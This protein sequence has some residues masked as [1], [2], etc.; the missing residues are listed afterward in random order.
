[1]TMVRPLPQYG[2]IDQIR[3]DADLKY[4]ALYI[5]A[6][7][8]YSHRNQFLV[9]YTYTDSDDNNPMG[10]YL[11]NFDLDLDYGPS[12]GERQHAIVASGS[13]L[14]PW[15][16]TLGALYTYRSELPWSATAGRDLNGDTFNTDLVPGTTRNAGARNLNLAAVNSY[17]QAN[18]L[19]PIAAADIDS[20]RISIMDMRVSKALRFGERK[21][22]LLAQAFNVLNTKNLQ[23]QFGGG[24]VG[25]ALS[26]TFGR[27]T[28]ARASR[29]I[30]LAVRL[31]W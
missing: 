1:V 31:M 28:S 7:K 6:E 23:A 18:G 24:R 22:D 14:L 29:Q 19:G 26:N 9:S 20:S 12:G 21:I 27:I 5:K 15:D 8:R 30:E 3:P 2:R 4:R 10:R 11:D 17:R 13:V 16:I 25:N